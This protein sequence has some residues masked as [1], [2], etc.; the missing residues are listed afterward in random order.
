MIKIFS[1]IQELRWFATRVLQLKHMVEVLTEEEKQIQE[2]PQEPCAARVFKYLGR[3]CWYQ[4]IQK[5]HK[6]KEEEA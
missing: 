2:M 5:Q 6:T 1:N 4:K 3:V